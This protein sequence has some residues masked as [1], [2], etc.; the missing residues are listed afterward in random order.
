M[1]KIKYK[2]KSDKTKYSIIIFKLNT[3]MCL[4]YVIKMEYVQ[5]TVSLDWNSSMSRYKVQLF[6]GKEKSSFNDAIL[7]ISFIH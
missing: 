6:A 5:K 1:F 2:H 4:H 3:N 7:S